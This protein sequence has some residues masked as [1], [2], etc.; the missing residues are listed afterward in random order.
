MPTGGFK[1]KIRFIQYWGERG[2]GVC[3]R[4]PVSF[5]QRFQGGELLVHVFLQLFS[6]GL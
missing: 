1:S 5:M 4:L 2:G 3:R 6:F